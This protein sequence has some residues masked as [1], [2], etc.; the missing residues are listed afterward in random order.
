M[1]FAGATDCFLTRWWVNGKAFGTFVIY[2]EDMRKKVVQLARVPQSI[3]RV[4]FLMEFE[5]KRIGAKPGDEVGCQLLYCPGGVVP[6]Y[7]GS[8]CAMAQVKALYSPMTAGPSLTLLSNR[9]EFTVPET[10]GVGTNAPQA[11]VSE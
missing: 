4:E 9:I 11:A 2:R 6:P 8:R 3:R 1:W 10:G 5:A 7:S